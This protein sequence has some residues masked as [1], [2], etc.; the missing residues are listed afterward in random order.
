M[1]RDE[2]AL[3]RLIAYV[4]GELPPAEAQAFEAEMAA[5]PA[6]AAEVIRHRALAERVGRAF[7]GVLDE[8]IPPQLLA[9]AHAANDRAGGR[10]RVAALPRWAALAAT[11]AVGVMAGRLALP[12]SGVLAQRDGALVAKG[13]LETALNT[14]LAAD[15]GAVKVGV[16]FKTADGRY[17]RTFESAPDRL[18]GLACRSDDHWAARTV[19]AWAPAAAQSAYRTAGSDTPPEVL[20]GVDS[21]IAGDPLDAKAE[22][23]ARDK[24]WK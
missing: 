22:R 9:T 23:A 13:R 21:L 4:D 10:P 14:Q 20:A 3:A 12:D 19:T 1:T 6:L 15:P 17:C 18:A 7:D 2:T 8:A 5:D 24:G 11:L 16:S